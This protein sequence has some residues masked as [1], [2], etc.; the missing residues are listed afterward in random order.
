M[1]AG[2]GKTAVLVVF[3]VLAAVVA[4]VSLAAW[5]LGQQRQARL[6][7]AP[8]PVVISSKV[9]ESPAPTA[10]TAPPPSAGVITTE[11]APYPYEE[12]YRGDHHEGGASTEA[13][14]SLSTPSVVEAV[15]PSSPAVPTPVP[16]PAVSA[17]PAPKGKD[18]PRKSATTPPPS[19]STPQVAGG[20]PS[21]QWLENGLKPQA[22]GGQ[23][24]IVIVIDDM[25]I[26]RKRSARI[27]DLPG[28]LTTSF[29]TYAQDGQAQAQAARRAGHEIMVHFPMEPENPT[30][31]PG[32]GV[33]RLS[34]SDEQNLRLLDE[35]L[36]HYKGFVGVNNHMGSKFTANADKMRPILADMKRRGLFFLDSRTIG[37]SKGYAVARS[38]GMATAG[39]DVFLDPEDRPG[40]VA[41]QLARLE[42]VAH[43]QGFAIA[44]G[45]PRDQTIETLQRWLPTLQ[46]KGLVLVPMS[47]IIRQHAGQQG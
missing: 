31:D 15:A 12:A 37:N 24:M 43:K 1:K 45:H 2:Q 10:P 46:Q 26:D 7:Q 27:I 19:V 11:S 44:I 8:P 20:M 14:V 17:P 9:E 21:P 36:S 39:R 22:T 16:P 30:I 3:A 33:L 28:P 4:A 5:F 40:I 23:A 38:L 29:L 42:K 34:Q 25:G 18:T 32:P 41:E 47:T 6:E 13:G 35:G